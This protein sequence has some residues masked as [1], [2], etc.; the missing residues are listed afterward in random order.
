[1]QGRFR[2][3]A[4][5][6][7]VAR[8]WRYLRLKKCDVKHDYSL[9][10]IHYSLTLCIFSPVKFIN[11]SYSDRLPLMPGFGGYATIRIYA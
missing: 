9:F 10:T 5:A 7:N 11:F 3:G 1:M 6:G 4:Q 8:I 2:R